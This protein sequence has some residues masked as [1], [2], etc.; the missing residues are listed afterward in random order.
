MTRPTAVRWHMIGL[1]VVMSAVGY[2]LRVNVS[3]AG[4]AMKTDLGLTEV[5]LGLV[6]SAFF[7]AYAL[8]QIPGGM[9]GEWLG[10]RRSLTWL[11]LGWGV[12]TL[13]IGLVPPRAH[14]PLWVI[15][16]SLVLLRGLQGA[17][18]APLYPI[19]TCGTMVTWLP[20]ARWGV[21]NAVTLIGQT[22]GSAATG[23][24]GVWLIM[25]LGWRTAIVAAGP[26]TFGL[27]AVW[28]W[29]NR[30]DPRDHWRVNAKELELIA[31][32]RQVAAAEARVDWASVV[33]NRNILLLTLSYFSMN[34]LF[35]L[36]FNW[37][38]YYLTDV[39]H[40]SPVTAG[41]FTGLQWVV[42]AV[43]AGAGGIIC[44]RLSAAF[45]VARGCRM[46]AM[47]GLLLATPCL[48]LGAVVSNP[49][50][51]VV[52]LSLSFASTMLVDSPYWVAT[53]RIAGP[54][55]PLAGGVLNTGGN[56]TGSVAAIL[57]PLIAQGFGWV[58][59]ICSGA[60]FGV[61]AAVLWIWIQADR[62]IEGR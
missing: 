18:Q 29:Y 53:A 13:L 14:A 33:L 61:T 25:H 27:A 35:Y 42:G 6:F 20:P 17:L 49:V 46:T 47:G 30:D 22:V 40:I 39:R 16:G 4:A 58:A 52:L 51:M 3:I 32:G 31:S 41:Y 10:P 34:Y 45:G 37:F 12:T 44:D 11:I 54:R 15:L 23:P 60:V 50:L 28:W 8:L 59:A 7:V 43:G 5:Q 56:L 38:F 36:F 55:A 19:S 48:L 2:M 1:L 26:L 62:P 9:F 24:I 21:G 57:V